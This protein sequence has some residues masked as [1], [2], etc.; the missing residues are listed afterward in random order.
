[1]QCGR[2]VLCVLLSS[3]GAS[4]QHLAL[5]DALDKGLVGKV[6]IDGG[7]APPGLAAIDAVCGGVAYPLGF[8]DA[9]GN[10][11]VV[12]TAGGA[13]FNVQTSRDNYSGLNDCEFRARLPGFRSRHISRHCFGEMADQE[14]ISIGT[15][16]LIPPAKNW[17]PPGPMDVDAKAAAAYKKG[18]GAMSRARSSDAQNQFERLWHWSPNIIPLGSGVVRPW[19]PCSVG[20]MPAPLTRRPWN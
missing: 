1:M 20:A 5:Q 2:M 16:P 4:A 3:M 10:F 7:A 18:A 9:D 19:K 15:L 8:A 12:L 17:Q 13:R 11:Q 14:T 6:K